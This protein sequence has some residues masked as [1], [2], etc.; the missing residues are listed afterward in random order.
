[1]SNF[2]LPPHPKSSGLIQRQDLSF[3]EDLGVWIGQRK[4]NGIHVVIWTNGK[5]VEIW[6]RTGKKLTFYKMSPS[7]E[8]CLSFLTKKEEI[9]VVGELLHC[10]AVNKTT[11]EQ[12]LKDTIVL[13]DILKFKT[14]LSNVL[15]EERLNLLADVCGNPKFLESPKFPG[16]TQ[17]A[18]IVKN[19]KESN[20]WLAER[21]DKEFSY[22]FDECCL[23]QVDGNHHD[24]YP[25]IEGLVL[26][27]KESKL[28]FKND[29][30]GDVDWIIKCRK[31][32]SKMYQ[33]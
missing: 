26:R 2:I 4:F 12:E 7:M 20:L 27:L 13:F 18:L 32:K 3:Y 25:E 8:Y 9:V 33:F 1:M 22:H 19:E 16:A 6:E 21:F 11:K 28:Q 23:D 15:Q 31:K 14:N 17:R 5:N 10:K 29:G 30:I 24:L